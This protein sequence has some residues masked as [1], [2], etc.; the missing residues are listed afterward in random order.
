M[1]A[2]RESATMAMA[3]QIYN[4][5]LL[6]PRKKLAP[7]C[8]PLCGSCCVV[9]PCGT[10]PGSVSN[11]CRARPSCSLRPDSSPGPGSFNVSAADKVRFA[12]SRGAV[13]PRATPP[14]PKVVPFASGT[15]A[16]TAS[17]PSSFADS[18][19]SKK[20][21]L[22]RHDRELVTAATLAKRTGAHGGG[23]AQGYTA[24]E[25]AY[26]RAAHVHD[27]SQEVRHKPFGGFHQ[28]PRNADANFFSTQ[29]AARQLSDK[30][31]A[32]GPGAYFHGTE[33]PT[34]VTRPRTAPVQFP[35]SPRFSAAMVRQ[36]GFTLP[37]FLAQP[38]GHTTN[39]AGTSPRNFVQVRAAL[40]WR[41][42]RVLGAWCRDP[43]PTC[44]LQE[45]SKHVT[46]RKTIPDEKT[47]KGRAEAAR[48]K[49]QR[50]KD[51]Q[52]ARCDLRL[53]K[54]A[55]REQRRLVRNNCFAPDACWVAHPV[56][57]WL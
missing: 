16:T 35:V 23:D 45:N 34:A 38:T 49:R 13:I 12:T 43:E 52:E 1:S 50:A 26:E 33:D 17:V 4:R 11:P 53:Q 55:A 54:V 3:L 19:K 51:V 41:V 2:A 56:D 47:A 46:T 30:G 36:G 39:Y 24:L 14:V 32:P 20:G 25:I 29:P 7:R 40:Q 8:V 28:S 48:A 10:L 6:G 57:W 9:L 5:R 27:I 15:A 31:E 37:N 21:V 18:R 44:L 42:C 22:Y